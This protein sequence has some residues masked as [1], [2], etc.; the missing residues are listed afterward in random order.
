MFPLNE[1]KR[2]KEKTDAEARFEIRKE[3]R[4]SLDSK[5]DSI[6]EID[7]EGVKAGSPLESLAAI[8]LKEAESEDAEVSEEVDV[9]TNDEGEDEADEKPIHVDPHLDETLNILSDYVRLV[10]GELAGKNVV[11]SK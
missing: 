11:F 6:F 9:A 4:A 3:Y 10:R 1:T 5:D 2:L 8:K 7:L